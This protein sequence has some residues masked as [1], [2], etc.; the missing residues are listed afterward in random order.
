MLLY[1]ITHLA[2]GIKK[3]VLWIFY[4]FLRNI[5]SDWKCSQIYV[6][7]LIITYFLKNIKR[8]N[9]YGI[10]A[11]KKRDSNNQQ[12][13][14]YRVRGGGKRSEVFRPRTDK[15]NGSCVIHFGILSIGKITKY[16]EEK[17]CIITL[18]MRKQ[19]APKVSSPPL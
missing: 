17:L 9:N 3:R 4:R 1:F 10:F 6:F 16:L 2:R 12:K 18:E 19:A 14:P 7:F 5:A 11:Y 15:Y 13:F 8:R